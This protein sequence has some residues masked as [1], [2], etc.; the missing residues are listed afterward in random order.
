MFPNIITIYSIPTPYTNVT[1]ALIRKTLVKPLNNMPEDPFSNYEDPTV[2]A[3][4]TFVYR[5][6]L[7]GTLFLV[8]EELRVAQKIV[9]L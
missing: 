9:P 3:A 4:T 5:R 1:A 6:P 7:K 2:T 8:L